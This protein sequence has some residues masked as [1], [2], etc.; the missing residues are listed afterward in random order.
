MTVAVSFR[1]AAWSNFSRRRFTSQDLAQSFAS[2]LPTIADWREAAREP[3]RIAR[4][5]IVNRRLSGGSIFWNNGKGCWSGSVYVGR[6]AKGGR[7]LKL[8][9]AGTQDLARQKLADFINTH[10]STL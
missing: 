8:V 9:S 3:R 5:P 6:D 2:T 7:I 4:Q 10:N 1:R